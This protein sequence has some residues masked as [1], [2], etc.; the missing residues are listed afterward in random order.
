MPSP[1]AT[2]SRIAD[3]PTLRQMLTVWLPLAASF[4]MMV[5][6]PSLVNIA[7]G[8]TRQPEL[9]LAAFGVA[10]SLV[11]LLEAPI[12]ML[13]DA[14]VAKSV[15]PVAF[16]LMRRLTLAMGFG[17]TAV[18]LVVSLTPL[19]GLIVRDLMNI[20]PDVALVARPTL[21]VLAF[22]SLPIAWR[23]THQGLLIREGRTSVVTVATGVRLATLSAALLLGL[24]LMPDRGALVAGLAMV[25]SI[26]AESALVTSATR[27]ILN[28]AAFRSRSPADST[29]T[30]RELWRFY[31]PL[32]TTTLLRQ[33]ARPML[34]AGIASATMARAS[35]AAWPVTWGFTML[36]TSPAWSLQQ[37]TTA[38]AADRA[39]L[40]RVRALA[41][42]LAVS[43]TLVLVLVAFTP[44]YRVV[45]GGLYN[46]S[47]AL[48]AL[49]RPALQ[50]L[51]IYPL[52]LA[53]L[54]VLRGVCIRSGRTG[55]VRS[56]MTANVLTL[57]AMLVVGA[58]VLSPTGV[59][60]AASAVLAGGAAEL[61]WLR[62]RAQG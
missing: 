13:I 43:L 54:A 1:A 10:F 6:E 16:T 9:A 60:L 32:A 17:V 11:L 26:T 2:E 3:G 40:R 25:L 12:F 37:V 41:L 62:W 55:N 24:R 34:S 39:A 35:L 27:L 58:T 50:L 45:L 49:A 18:G 42:A 44:L 14:S 46:L 23:R 5:L 7:L 53:G 48:Q 36:V 52:L 8:R 56:A 29:L 20:P 57:A 4:L 21:Q 15:D 59:M 19:Y 28:T 61:A 51:T 22:Y 30:M 38:L 47:P 31:R 33:S